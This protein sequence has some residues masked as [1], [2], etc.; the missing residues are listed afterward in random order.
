[1]VATF[2]ITSRRGLQS[3]TAWFQSR[4]YLDS[5]LPMSVNRCAY[6]KAEIL[7]ERTAAWQ[8]QI[9]CAF[10][11]DQKAL[12]NGTQNY[13]G[14]RRDKLAT[15]SKYVELIGSRFLHSM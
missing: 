9:A 3:L 4:A 6:P 15:G 12:H 2:T 1:M 13:F 8:R 7:A 14:F 10:R 11:R 5:N